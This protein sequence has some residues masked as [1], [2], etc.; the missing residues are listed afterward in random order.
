MLHAAQ[1]RRRA[2]CL[3]QLGEEAHLLSS[4]EQLGRQTVA[5]LRSGRR[6]PSLATRS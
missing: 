2:E 6:I 4:T 5:A 3:P 1:A